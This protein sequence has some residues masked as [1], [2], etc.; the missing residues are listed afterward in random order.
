M[1]KSLICI[2][3]TLSTLFIACNSS[4]Q[5]KKDKLNGDATKELLQ[6]KH[7]KK[8]INGLTF[9]ADIIINNRESI[10]ENSFVKTTASMVVSD[11]DKLIQTFFKD[12]KIEKKTTDDYS[13]NL[14]KEDS[15]TRIFGPNTSI[16][17]FNSKSSFNLQFRNNKFVDY[18]TNSFCF[19]DD[20]TTNNANKYS[21][22]KNLPFATREEAFKNI[23]STM[24]SVGFDIGTNYK[25]YALDHETLKKEEF[26]MDIDGS[27]D[28]DSHKA[29]WSKEDDCYYFFIRPTFN[30]IPC[31]YQFTKGKVSKFKLQDLMAPIQVIY[32]KAGIQF[33]YIDGIFSMTSA[34]EKVPLVPFD[35]IAERVAKI[36]SNILGGSTYKVTKAT[37]VYRIDTTKTTDSFPVSLAW[38]LNIEESGNNLYESNTEMLVDAVTGKEILDGK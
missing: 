11:G 14:G 38:A 10:T 5:T 12:K 17:Y 16:L 18:I 4:S 24:A 27:D 31:L 19:R 29:S 26:A 3:L 2:I 13:N 34:G 28:L 9:D 15:A 30:D 8:D 35:T 22:V 32:T 6:M 37:L 36:Y 1:K 7:Y 21:L 33:F 20:E 25:A 23:S